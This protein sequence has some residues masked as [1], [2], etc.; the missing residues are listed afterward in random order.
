[1]RAG[2]R[3]EERDADTFL[4]QDLEVCRSRGGFRER[5]SILDQRGNHGPAKKYFCVLL[6]A[7]QQPFETR[8]WNVHQTISLRD[9]E[10]I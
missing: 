1:M 7:Q 4:G 8:R 6:K 5:G 3:D 10:R 2:S 9:A